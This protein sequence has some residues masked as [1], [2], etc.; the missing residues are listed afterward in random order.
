MKATSLRT[1]CDNGAWRWTLIAVV[2]ALWPVT[3]T[4]QP[5]DLVALMRH[6]TELSRTGRYAE[7]IPH[8][9]RLVT[10]AEKMASKI[11]RSL[12]LLTFRI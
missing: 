7:A 10:E 12:S 9:Q 4:A 1:G 3:A 5:E 6:I 2:L 8:A 11:S